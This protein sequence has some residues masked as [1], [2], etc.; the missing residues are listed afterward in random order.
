VL[1]STREGSSRATLGTTGKTSSLLSYYVQIDVQHLVDQYKFFH[2]QTKS[3][4]FDKTHGKTKNM[5]K[6]RGARRQQ[7]TVGV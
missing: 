5:H 6:A 4:E 1:N 3:R 2:F 7:K